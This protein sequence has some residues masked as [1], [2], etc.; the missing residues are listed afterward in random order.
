MIPKEDKQSLIS[1]LRME[2][3]NFDDNWLEISVCDLDWVFEDD[4]DEDEDV[5]E[6]EEEEKADEN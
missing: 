5:D 2:G 4:L 6:E 3:Y 1:L